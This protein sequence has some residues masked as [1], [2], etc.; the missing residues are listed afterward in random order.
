M[1]NV[2][3]IMMPA[4]AIMMRTTFIMTTVVPIMTRA[5]F[6]TTKVIPAMIF[7]DAI[8]TKPAILAWKRGWRVVG[9]SEARLSEEGSEAGGDGIEAARQ[10]G[11]EGRMRCA[12][13]LFCSVPRCRGRSPHASMPPR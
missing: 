12:A 8:T 6:I 9:R 2:V 10:H 13:D 5:V 4:A 11:I 1:T 3:P 7:S